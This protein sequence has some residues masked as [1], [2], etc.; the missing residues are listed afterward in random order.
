MEA[1]KR[2]LT[3]I[4]MCAAKGGTKPWAWI[5]LFQHVCR[6]AD[7]LGL[8]VNMNNDAGWCGSGGPWITPDLAMQKVVSRSLG[9]S[10]QLALFP[11]ELLA[12]V[13]SLGKVYAPILSQQ[14]KH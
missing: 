6:E 4:T 11:I 12:T 7:R 2:A 1:S 8:K 10:P 14:R 3:C 5:E 13:P 9:A